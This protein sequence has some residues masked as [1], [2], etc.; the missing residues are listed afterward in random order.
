MDRRSLWNDRGLI[1][2]GY[3][4]VSTRLG[5][6]YPVF[7]YAGGVRVP[8]RLHRDRYHTS[9]TVLQAEPDFNLQLP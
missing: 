2:R 4:Y 5:R 3:L 6:G 1:V 9:S 7:I 8:L